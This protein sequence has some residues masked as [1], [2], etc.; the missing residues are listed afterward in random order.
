M[1]EIERGGN[2]IDTDMETFGQHIPEVCS[3][4][5][6]SD[7]TRKSRLMPLILA[8]KTRQYR[9]LLLSDRLDKIVLFSFHPR[10]HHGVVSQMDRY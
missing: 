10:H 2:K 7:A 1:L 8:C 6:A 4:P 3:K 9:R 5:M